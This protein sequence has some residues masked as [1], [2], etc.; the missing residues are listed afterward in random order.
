MENLPHRACGLRRVRTASKNASK[1]L[2]VCLFLPPC[3]LFEVV[4]L[5]LNFFFLVL[6][7]FTIVGSPNQPTKPEEPCVS[8]ILR[9]NIAFPAREG[10]SSSVVPHGGAGS[11]FWDRVLSIRKGSFFSAGRLV[12]PGRQRGMIEI[13]RILSCFLRKDCKKSNSPHKCVFNREK[14]KGKDQKGL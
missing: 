5:E 1:L 2:I 13:S 14:H 6:V 3:R 9:R 4:S 11:G 12:K 7:S 10:R 8:T